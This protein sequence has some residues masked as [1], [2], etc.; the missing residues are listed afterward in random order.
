ML[1]YSIPRQYYIRGARPGDIVQ[2]PT[3]CSLATLAWAVYKACHDYLG[4]LPLTTGSGVV[5][6]TRRQLEVAFDLGVTHWVSFPEYL[7]KLAQTCREELGRDVK[8]LG[9]KFISSYLGPDLD[10]SLRAQL[11]GL[12]G[13]PVYDS[14][15]TNEIGA[16]SFECPHRGGLHLAEDLMY[17]E[18]LDVETNQPLPQGEVG[19]LAITVFH[20]HVQ[21]VIRFNLRDLGRILP[22]QSCGCGSSFR[23]MD[24]MLGRSDS[25]VK[26]RGVNVYPM[27]CLRGVRSDPR[28]TGEWLC[29]THVTSVGGVPREELRV[30]VEV[31]KDVHD[32]RGLK[33]KLEGRLKIDL[34]ISVDVH[35]T[36][37]GA[38]GTDAHLGEGKVKRLLERR[39]GYRSGR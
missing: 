12:W 23:R 34:G 26:I 30:H 31:R 13:C 20:R 39:P 37:E 10:G 1:A 22:T 5:M 21:P 24:H 4:I 25:M 28:T 17:F 11:E 18:V 27:A 3:T 7:M 14:Y 2:I 19:N 8:E 35:L 32:R 38:L 16:A 33:E 15:G 6:S 29:E 9:T 36:E